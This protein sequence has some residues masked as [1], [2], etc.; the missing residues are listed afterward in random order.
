MATKS[1]AKITKMTGVEYLLTAHHGYTND[2]KNAV[3]DWKE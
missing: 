1:I 2:Y 3:K